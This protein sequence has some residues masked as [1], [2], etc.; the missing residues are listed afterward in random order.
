MDGTENQT[1]A[2]EVFVCVISGA[3]GGLII[4]LV[5]E[6]YTSHSYA[7]VREVRG[8]LDIMHGCAV[9][10]RMVVF[11]CP[12]L[13]VG[14]RRSVF[15]MF[16]FAILASVGETAVKSRLGLGYLRIQLLLSTCF[17]FF[18]STYCWCPC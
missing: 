5:T 3:V 8:H 1:G 17:R 12:L 13:V 10:S 9:L 4:G 11:V 14:Q 15:G 16:F 7:P 18:V 6:Y 2:M